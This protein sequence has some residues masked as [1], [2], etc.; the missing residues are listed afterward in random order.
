MGKF[1][2]IGQAAGRRGED[3]MRFNDFELGPAS[4]PVAS[5][6]AGAEGHAP[7]V[8]LIRAVPRTPKPD[9]G[10][11]K[12]RFKR[13]LGIARVAAAALA[14]VLLVG[15]YPAMMVMAHEIDSSPTSVAMT[16]A[17]DGVLEHVRQLVEREADGKGWAGDVP[18]WHPA[19]RLTAMPAWQEGL[20]E[21]L[22]DVLATQS[23]LLSGGAE[24]DRELMMASRLL[25][26]RE[27]GRMEARLLGAS[28][29]LSRHTAQQAQSGTAAPD[30][31]RSL[32]AHT[33]L[34]LSWAST[35]GAA[36]DAVTS[37]TD[38][39]LARREA[40]RAFSAARARAQAARAVL[41][42]LR[43][44]A[45]LQGGLQPAQSMALDEAIAAWGRVAESAPLVVTNG[46]AGRLPGSDLMS[47]GYL[48]AKAARIT[49]SLRD[50]AGPVEAPR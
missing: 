13:A 24:T 17:S 16:P 1:E 26:V 9:D 25:R 11:L 37:D 33:D 39:L 15:S 5:G 49:Q 36:I 4:G 35:S 43:D 41:A 23:A 18:V 45:V 31:L 22:A 20:A 21:A 14:A 27:E 28:E 50:L 46:E 42:G 48:T 44:N 30:V 12:A 32:E 34:I 7:V 2:H 38:T 8:T 6:R 40:I 19:A 29:A 10:R 47:L 3:T